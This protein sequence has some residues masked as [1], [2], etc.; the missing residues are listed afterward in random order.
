MVSVF[1]RALS[2]WVLKLG[3]LS[4]VG[5]GAVFYF[6][7]GLGPKSIITQQLLQRQQ[8][9]ARAEASNITSFFQIFGDAVVVLAQLSS[10]K[11]QNV[12]T[13]QDMDVFVERW[14]DDNLIGGVALTDKNGVVRFNSN[15]FQTSDVGV[16]LADRDYF[17]WAKNQSKEGEYFIGQPVINRLEAT[18]GQLIVPV[19]AP[20]YQQGVFAGTV[21]ASVKLKPLTELY[22]QMMKVSGETEVYVI[23]DHGGLLYSSPAPDVV[24]SSIFELFPELKNILNPTKEDK[25]HAAQRLIAYSPIQ[26]GS[27]NWSL[28]MASPIQYTV[29]LTA[30]V[31]LRLVAVLLLAFLTGL[32]L[33]I[34]VTRSKQIQKVL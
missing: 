12:T 13:Q 31:Y 25:L 27:Q 29:G 22:L 23:G 33:G 34:V 32:L 19:A 24:G 5:L 14:R 6:V 10:M 15:L 9:M 18:E 4:V 30:P 3:L 20:V 26:L 7:L 21:V 16:T 8:V 28:I 2:S 1:R 11:S 17:L